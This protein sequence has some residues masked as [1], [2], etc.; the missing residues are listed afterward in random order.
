M[1]K[2][3]FVG[4]PAGNAKQKN[5]SV[6][7]SV[8]IPGARHIKIRQDGQNYIFSGI[9]PKQF[10]EMP[11]AR[12][13]GRFTSG[14]GAKQV[15]SGNQK[16]FEISKQVQGQTNRISFGLYNTAKKF[17][18]P[19]AYVPIG[20]DEFL[21]YEKFF[22]GYLAIPAAVIA[23]GVAVGLAFAAP[24]GFPVNPLGIAP[25]V[26]I[27]GDGSEPSTEVEMIDFAGFD[28]VTVNQ[29]NP[30]VL[31]QNPETNDVYFSYVVSDSAGK[32]IMT[33]D[34]IPPGKALQWN[35]RKD[36]GGGVHTVKLHVDTYDMEDTSIPYNAMN[37]DDVKITVQ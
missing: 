25:T 22:A 6:L 9:S 20:N 27:G 11:G 24:G 21:V 28:S 4:R 32:E 29:N 33:T 15:V 26:A 12:V 19:V 31:L 10:R 1:K 16:T 14:K 17:F 2:R 7:H 13:V 34:L 36:L 5:D 18:R 37:Y 8:H 30:Y 23:A 35:P 3:N